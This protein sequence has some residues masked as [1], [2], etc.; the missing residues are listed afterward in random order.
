V[1]VNVGTFNQNYNVNTDGFVFN[2]R[3]Y[4]FEPALTPSSRDDC[5]NGGWQT[6]NSP[7]FNNQ[8]RCIQYVNN[9]NVTVRGNNVR[10]NANGLN[11][12]A[13]FDMDTAS[14]RGTFRYSDANGDFY[15]VRVTEVSA[16]ANDDTAYFA[17][18]VTRASN[19]A[20]VG[21]WLFAK[22]ED[23]NPDKIWGS[24]TNEATATAGVE[25]MT[26][27]ADGP[28]TVNRGNIR[29]RD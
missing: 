7:S 27:P 19:P 14:D 16:N 9:H 6:F 20:W 23:N 18:V 21:Q 11:R 8:G 3:T 4:D 26:N 5:R 28:F 1:G 10:Y 24:F 22:V 25:N 29:V 15:R 2:N 13:E 17:G 12:T